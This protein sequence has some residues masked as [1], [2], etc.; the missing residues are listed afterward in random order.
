MYKATTQWL[1]AETLTFVESR[2]V[3]FPS[4]IQYCAL[5]FVYI[6]KETAVFAVKAG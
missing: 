4:L 1:L 5:V 2:C 3:T 6:S